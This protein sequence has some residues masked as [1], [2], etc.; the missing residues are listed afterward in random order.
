MDIA[1]GHE[2]LV[3][4]RHVSRLY[5]SVRALDEVSLTIRRGEMVSVM[6]PS[7]SGTSGGRIKL[8]TRK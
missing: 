3:D 1:S 4:V 7:G 2:P 6:G 8:A 5:G